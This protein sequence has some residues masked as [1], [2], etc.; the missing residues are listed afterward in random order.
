M[1]PA[2]PEKLTRCGLEDV[3]KF[4]YTNRS[5]LPYLFLC[6]LD[7]RYELKWYEP[8]PPRTT[9]VEVKRDAIDQTIQRAVRLGVNHKAGAL[10]LFAIFSARPLEARELEA[11]AA[12]AKRA[13]TPLAKLSA[14]ALE[15]AASLEQRSLLLQLSAP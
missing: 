3:L 10:R 6:G 7:E 9:S 2:A 11:A 8:H 14:L 15:G 4:A 12:A 13:K 5:P 1:D